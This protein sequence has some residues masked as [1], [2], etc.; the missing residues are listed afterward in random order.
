MS[1]S[2]G[3]ASTNQKRFEYDSLNG[4]SRS[5]RMNES[6]RIFEIMLASILPKNRTFRRTKSNKVI[7]INDYDYKRNVKQF[8]NHI[9]FQ[10]KVNKI[11]SPL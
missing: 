7:F 9:Y 5:I 1:H 3:G 8:K 4:P 11:T 2:S 10:N 6:S